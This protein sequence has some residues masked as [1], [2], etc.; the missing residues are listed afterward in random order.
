VYKSFSLICRKLET[1]GNSV[2]W[3]NEKMNTFFL[4]P[5]QTNSQLLKGVGILSFEE[6]NLLNLRQ[7]LEMCMYLQ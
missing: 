7:D 4:E 2:G 5:V 3:Q 6:C 1:V